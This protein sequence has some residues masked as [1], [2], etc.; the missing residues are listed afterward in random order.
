MESA[1]FEQHHGIYSEGYPS[2]IFLN[3]EA[4]VSKVSLKPMAINMFQR[5]FFFAVDSVCG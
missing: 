5:L 2:F 3:I 4:D 1:L